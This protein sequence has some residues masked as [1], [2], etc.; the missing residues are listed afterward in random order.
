M[1]NIIKN[2]LAACAAASMILSAGARSTAETPAGSISVASDPQGAV[3][4]V[5]GETRGNTPIT[6]SGITAGKHLVEVSAPL[7]DTAYSTVSVSA[8]S[9]APLVVTLTKLRGIALI[10]SAP[11]GAVVTLD[12]INTGVTPL[13]VSDIDMGRYSVQLSLTGYQPKTYELEID[14]TEPRQIHA[15]L[16]SSTASLSVSSDPSGASVSVNGVPRGNTPCAVPEIPEGPAIIEVSAQGYKE[17]REQIT[18]SA[19][20]DVSVNIPL[21]PIPAE[22]TVVTIP[23][24]A[25]IYRDNQFA[26]LSPVTIRDLPAGEY[27]IRAEADGFD[28][29]ARSVVLSRAESRTEEFRMRPNGGAISVVTSPAGVDISINGKLRGTTSSGTNATDRISEPIVI[30]PVLE[31]PC[32]IVFTRKGYKDARRKITVERDKTA[33]LDTVFLER[34][35]IPD[36]EVTTR[37]KVY[38]GMFVSRDREFIKLETSPGVIT[39]LEVPDIVRVRLIKAENIKEDAE[40]PLHD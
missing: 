24:K 30:S 14:S 11:T 15:E 21:E 27:R 5:D 7:H 16:V 18:L 1:K 38:T 13:L 9:V 36:Y 20:D 29:M 12:G 39:S 34:L 17:Y 37:T 19:G 6:V 31:G 8:G 3:V 28:A 2:A 23:D 35:F 22:L 25:R 26:G 33:N 32:E 10:T 40:S 4:K